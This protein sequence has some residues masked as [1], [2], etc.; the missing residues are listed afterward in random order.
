MSQSCGDE[1]GE[2]PFRPSREEGSLSR[3]S[4]RRPEPRPERNRQSDER[5]GD[6]SEPCRALPRDEAVGRSRA[7]AEV[8]STVPWGTAGLDS[9]GTM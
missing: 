5:D 1:N 9:V 8:P 3:N 2:R 6:L 7:W 4:K